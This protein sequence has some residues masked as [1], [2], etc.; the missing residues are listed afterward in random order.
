MGART[1]RV[2]LSQ[3]GKDAGGSGES[4]GSAKGGGT[5]SDDGR[6]AGGRGLLSAGDGAAADGREAGR[7]RKRVAGGAGGAGN[8]D[9]LVDDSRDDGRDGGRDGLDRGGGADRGGR[10]QRGAVGRRRREVR[11]RVL[12]RGQSLALLGS[13]L[14]GSDGAHS[15]VGRGLSHHNVRNGADSG[16]VD[17]RGGQVGSGGRAAGA[18]GDLGAARS[19]RNVLVRGEGALGL[20]GGQ[21]SASKGNGSE[22]ETHL[23]GLLKKG[24]ARNEGLLRE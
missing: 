10:H 1:E 5:G 12:R 7:G 15:R 3:E 9:R 23:G 21:D 14:G 24:F 22:S 2:N 8:L 11:A 4:S 6:R 20:L 17:G 19:D 16:A 13:C 18:V